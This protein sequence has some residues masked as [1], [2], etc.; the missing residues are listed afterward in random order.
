LRTLFV[1]LLTQFRKNREWT[2]LLVFSKSFVHCFKNSMN[3]LRR[4]RVVS[5]LGIRSGLTFSWRGRAISVAPSF[6]AARARR[7]ARR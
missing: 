2:P 5:I 1:T 7:T 4:R 6:A 3:L